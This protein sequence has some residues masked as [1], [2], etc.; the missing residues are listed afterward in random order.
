MMNKKKIKS[1]LTDDYLHLLW[2]HAYWKETLQNAIFNKE[3]LDVDAISKD[4]TCDL[5]KWLLEEHKHHI[6]DLKSYRNLVEKHA[7]FHIEAGKLAKLAN[8][9]QYDDAQK[10]L[11]EATEF[12]HAAEAVI[13]ALF[14]LKEETD[15]LK[16]HV[17]TPEA[18]VHSRCFRIFNSKDF[19]DRHW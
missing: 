13:S 9:R 17:K 12:A 6:S 5:G 18:Y 7:E 14:R 10:L 2:S 11:D 3:S 4:N 15:K 19:E 8:T 16:K 1:E